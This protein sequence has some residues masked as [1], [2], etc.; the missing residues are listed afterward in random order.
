VGKK[1]RTLR[2]INEKIDRGEAVVL[3]ADEMKRL[4]EEKGVKVAAKE[5]DVVC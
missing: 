3:T 4:V 2:E 1:I 5:V